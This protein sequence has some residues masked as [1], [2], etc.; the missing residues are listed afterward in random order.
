MDGR[1]TGTDSHSAFLDVPGARIYYEV[2][3]TGPLLVLIPGAAGSVEPYRRLAGELAPRFTVVTYDRRGFSR[4]TLVGEQDYGRRLETD[5]DDVAA[6]VTHLG[7][8]PA[9]AFGNSSGATVALEFLV[10]HP[11]LGSRV[12]AHEAPVMMELA[13]ADEWVAFFSSLYELYRRSGPEAA[14]ERFRERSFPE[15]D[16]RV[17]AHVPAN[18]FSAAN[19]AF[20]FEH[21]LRQYP[22]VKLDHRSL[23]AHADRLVLAVGGESHGYPCREAAVALGRTIGCPVAELPGGHVAFVAQAPLFARALAPLLVTEGADTMA[24]RD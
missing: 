21:E 16:R 4:S 24:L 19:A 11:S 5:A 3:G 2:S 13:D 17:M 15:S 9:A 23:K 18:E 22:A 10:R 1:P 20:W 8:G 12:G 7:D 14:M 6:L